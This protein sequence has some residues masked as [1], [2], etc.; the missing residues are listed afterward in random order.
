MGESIDQQSIGGDGTREGVHSDLAR[1]RA[2]AH[3][4]LE[5][6][7]GVFVAGAHGSGRRGF[8][9]DVAAG[10]SDRTRSR[11]WLGEDLH[12]F[13]DVRAAKLARAVSGRHLL[14]FASLVESRGLPGDLSQ[15]IH[16]ESVLRIE[17]R[18]R[19]PR[20]LLH[21][22]ETMLGGPVDDSAASRLIPHSGGADLS[23]LREAI[24]GARHSGAL[25]F[26]TGAWRLHGRIV[27]NETLRR[28]CHSRVAAPRIDGL[29]DILLD[30]IALVPG[31]SL[32]TV[33]AVVETLGIDGPVEAELERLE[34]TGTL[35]LVEEVGEPRL[36]LREGL[37]ELQLPNTLG[38]LRRHRLAE[39][40]VDVLGRGVVTE[41]AS[42]EAVGFADLALALGRPVDSATLV[43]AARMSLRSRDQALSMRLASAAVESGGG[44]DAE[45][46]LAT[47]EL[48]SG[49]SADALA[50]LRALAESAGDDLQRQDA[51]ASLVRHAHERSMGAGAVEQT[52]RNPGADDR[53]T[54]LKR[55]AMTGFLL[56]SLDDPTGASDLLE[57]AL[58]ALGDADRA[59][60][61]FIVANGAFI[62]GRLAR[63]RESL[64]A[65]ELLL[66]AGGSD[67]SRVRM[68]RANV[69]A[70]DG[71]IVESLQ[72]VS[73]FRD[74]A[75]A[76]R[77]VVPQAMCS[78]AAGVL[79][80]HLGRA[81]DAAGELG[82]AVHIM[83][84]EGLLGTALLARTAL[85]TALAHTGDERAARQAL[86]PAMAVTAAGV[87]FEGQVHQAEG[88]VHLAGGREQA[89]QTSMLRAA[90]FF[91][92][93]GYF[94][95]A[96]VALRDAARVGMARAVLP[97][98]D[99]L[100]LV[101]EGDLMAVSVALCRALA[102]AE[103]S[104]DGEP[105]DRA[106]LARSFDD[107]GEQAEAIG[108]HL[109]AAE[110]FDRAAEFHRSLGADREASAS[111]RRRDRHLREC[112]AGRPLLVERDD[113][114]HLSERELEI[115]RLAASGQSNRQIADTLVLSV[116]TVETHLQKVYRK[117]GLRTRSEIANVLGVP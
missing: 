41:G 39:A 26:D 5:S 51:L 63:A 79:L 114:A 115:A 110:A 31:I 60:A 29:T 80:D 84:Q 58:A 83:E 105:V 100:A 93:R 34:D 46:T 106:A 117:L 113:S 67:T 52:G 22:A 7:I 47:A 49:R 45:M 108:M 97:R 20:M 68:L 103:S 88:W 86:E 116:R 28:L 40:V 112:G 2:D 53:A 111:A 13:D 14:P 4:A 81:A 17:L 99:D 89:A 101:V 72:T 16:D 55:D 74:F 95:A 6:G 50:R 33:L 107:A 27:P 61:H 94:L 43:H 30:V 57:P 82:D 18:A 92:A 24:H 65:A 98:M 35:D 96:G 48:Q 90:D 1:E 3:D 36:R 8:L 21:I 32:R 85:A 11:V 64:D 37:W 9:R 59:Y 75:A 76:Y 73:A 109:L 15:L 71:R 56:F 10:L 69:D 91:V 23:V 54:Q 38:V 70:A 78:W 77:Q 19:S 62:S 44:F 66:T 102:G 25:V 104:R 12:S 87:R 42:N